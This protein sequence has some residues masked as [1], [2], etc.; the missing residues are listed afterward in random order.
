MARPY[1]LDL[2]ERVVAR[3]EAGDSCRAVA[4]LFGVSVASV[5]KWSQRKRQ[6]GSAAARPMGGKRRYAVAGE[7]DWLLARVA[8]TPDV[9]LRALVVELAARGVTVSYFAVWHFFENEGIT[10]KKK[11]CAPVN[12]TVRTSRGG[13]SAGRRIRTSSIRHDWSSST[14]PGPKPT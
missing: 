5:V 14:R 10:F 2:R 9:T 1:S 6:T 8:E 13:G 12:R 4:A 11:V 7:R 3:V